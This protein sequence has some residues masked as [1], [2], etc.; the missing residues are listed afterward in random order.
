MKSKNPHSGCNEVTIC[1]TVDTAALNPSANQGGIAIVQ[2]PIVFYGNRVDD[3]RIQGEVVNTLQARMGTGGGN[4]P[5]VAIQGNMIGRADSAG[6]QGKGYTEE[7]EPMFTLTKTDVHAVAS[8]S[9][10]RRL[11]PK[12][13]ERLQGF[14]DGWT[15]PQTDGHRYRQLGNAVAVPVVEFVIKRLV[16][17]HGL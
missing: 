6:P 3:I 12:E 13:C 14:P 7:G 8:S 4:M 1:K 16:E 9:I 2:E 17:L 11:T 15:E 5:L 10:V